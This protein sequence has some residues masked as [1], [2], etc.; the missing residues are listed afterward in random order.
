VTA[1]GFGIF[2]HASGRPCLIF[3]RL[4]FAGQKSVAEDTVVDSALHDSIVPPQGG[5][6]WSI[7]SLSPLLRG[8]DLFG[9]FDHVNNCVV[10]KRRAE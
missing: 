6:F 7:L 8:K 1:V 10:A 2:R 3:T 9:R 5:K 4:N